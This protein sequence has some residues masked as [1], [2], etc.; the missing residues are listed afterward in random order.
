MQRKNTAL[1]MLLLLLVPAALVAET[2]IGVS[3]FTNLA[4]EKAVQWLEI[5]IAD[6]VS[7]KLRNVRDYIVVERTNVDKIIHEVQLGQTGVL[8]DKKA[9]QAGKALGADIIVVGNFQKYGNRIRIT[10]KLVEVESHKIL[11]QVESTGVMDNI[12]ELQDEIALKIIDQTNIKITADVKNR[13]TENF[14]KNISAYEYYVKGMSNLLYQLNY[15]E[16]IKWF[17]KAI[18]VDKNYSLAYSGLG[19][20]YSLRRWELKNYENRIDDSLLEKSY[21][22]SRRAL[23]LSPN[24]DEAHIALA[25]YY[26]EVDDKKVPNKWK[27]CEAETRKAI[28]INPNNAEAY[29]LLSRIYGYNDAQEEKYLLISIE[30]N[31]FLTDAHNNLAVIYLDQKKLDLAEKYFKNTIEIDPEFKTGYMNLGVVYDRKGQ[32]ERALEMYQVVLKKY[33]T[34]ILGLRNLGIGYRR[35]NRLDEA[36]AQFRKAVKVKSDDYQTWSEIAYISLVKKDYREAIKNYHVALKHNPTYYFTLSNLGYCYGE[37]GDFKNAVKYLTDCHN[38]HRD[39]AWPA[40]H[41]GWIY[42]NKLKDNAQAKYWYG[43]ALKREPNNSGYQ[44]NFNQL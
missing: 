2:V 27:L 40:G 18:G 19:K 1:I 24:L 3:A 29:F 14:T 36:M 26:Q 23:D 33:P 38:Q 17:D 31:K 9:K 25:R 16:A 20:A 28:E 12:F 34:Y 11:K 8:D 6:S 37:V 42:R 35:L 13:I 21:Q 7:H 15:L 22:N 4:G 32:L 41:L 43:E 10:A 30:K 5:G 39:K 44:Q